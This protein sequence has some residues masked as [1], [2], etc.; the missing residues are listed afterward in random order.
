MD[1]VLAGFCVNLR[2]ARVITMEGSSVKEI[3]P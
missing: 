1:T 3:P 2:Q